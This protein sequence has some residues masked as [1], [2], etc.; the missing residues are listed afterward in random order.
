MSFRSSLLPA[1]LMVLAAPAVASAAAV[2]VV[3]YDMN[4]GNGITQFTF[5]KN[6]FDFN[7]TDNS[8][9]TV[10]SSAGKNGSGLYIPTNASPQEAWLTGGK[11][12][13]T[14]KVIPTVPYGDVTSATSSQY[15][16]WKYQDP[17]IT[18]HLAGSQL[19]STISLY[20]ATNTGSIYDGLVAAPKDVILTLSDGSAI[21]YTETISSYLGS[22]YTS[23]ITLTLANAVSSDL[24][25]SL[26]LERGP[27]QN[28]GI[29]YYN[30]HVK[31]YDP[32]HPYDASQ[33]AG[34]CDPDPGPGVDPKFASG[35]RA[36]AAGGQVGDLSNPGLEPWILLS[37]VTFASP[38]PEPSTWIMMI[39]GFFGIGMFGYRRRRHHSVA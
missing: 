13:L 26:T 3:S 4:N 7:Y 8:T 21:S 33:C 14:D 6:Y 15:V 27:L 22:P 36:Q 30:D 9:A 29:A 10:N 35:F 31:G 11:G 39:V 20:V 2:E 19:V 37:E 23:V 1:F 32:A 24:A 12:L 17:T 18:F 34:W 28:D 38:V 25:F 5:D 16:G